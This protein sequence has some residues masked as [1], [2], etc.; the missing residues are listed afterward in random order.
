MSGRIISTTARQ[1]SVRDANDR[2]SEG[3]DH[4]RESK[5]NEALVAYQA[6]LNQL[7]KR[8]PAIDEDSVH[9][10]T[11]ETDYDDDSREQ[12]SASSSNSRGETS[13][14]AAVERD[15]SEAASGLV[16]EEDPEV[17]Q[18]R[19]VLSSNIGA[20]HVKLPP[21]ILEGEFKEAV[22]ACTEALKDNPVYERAL[23]RR[24]G[25][26]EA[27]NTWSSLTAAQ[28][29]YKMLKELLAS[30]AQKAEVDSKM[31]SL[32]PRVEAAQKKETAEMVDK[33]KGF[34]NS[35]LGRFGLSTDNFKL[36]PNGQGGY[37]MDFKP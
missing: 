34:G 3:N 32:L 31:R 25:S 33:L 18:L 27:I 28:E 9:S 20:C 16:Q 29:D 12:H 26:N 8:K 35:I 22:A 13:E 37:S 1:D 15:S 36:E 5:W 24:A 17:V 19:S 21:D 11:N 30:P 23:R 6:G 2:K 7:P 4:F 10:S 14:D